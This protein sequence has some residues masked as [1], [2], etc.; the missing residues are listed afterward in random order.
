M[1]IYDYYGNGFVVSRYNS[2]QRIYLDTDRGNVAL[3]LEKELG[4]EFSDACQKQQIEECGLCYG[5]VLKLTKSLESR[6]SFDLH[7][8]T[9]QQIW[10]EMTVPDEGKPYHLTSEIKHTSYDDTYKP[11]KQWLTKIET[12]LIEGGINAVLQINSAEVSA[13]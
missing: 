8:G 3:S 11:L 13:I 6:Y 10:L 2:Q 7:F 1:R 9:K 12:Q 4:Y 5:D